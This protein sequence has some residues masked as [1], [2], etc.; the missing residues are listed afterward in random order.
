MPTRSGVEFLTPAPM[1]GS[2]TG[3]PSFPEVVVKLD[4]LMVRMEQMEQRFAESEQ[5]LEE[6]VTEST[7]VVQGMVGRVLALERPPPTQDQAPGNQPARR[8]PVEPPHRVEQHVG[9]GVDEDVSDYDSTEEVGNDFRPAAARERVDLGYDHRFFR[10]PRDRDDRNNVGFE[11][12]RHQYPRGCGDRDEHGLEYRRYRPPRDRDD[13]DDEDDRRIVHVDAPTFDGSLDPRAYLDWEANMNRYFDWMGMSDA[14][15]TRFAMIKLVGQA[16]TYWLNVDALLEQRGLMPIESWED[17]KVKLREKYLPTTYRHRLIDRWQDLTQGTRIVFEYIADFDEYLLR[18]GACEEGAMTLSRFRKGLRRVYQHELFRQHVTTIEHNY[19]VVSEMEQFE[20][21]RESPPRARPAYPRPTKQR[22]A[23]RLPPRGPTLGPTEPPP[24]PRFL[25]PREAAPVLPTP[26]TRPQLPAPPVRRD[27]KGKAPM[28]GGVSQDSGS[29]NRCFRCQG[30][31]HYM[32]ACPTRALTIEGIDP[33]GSSYD[34][35]EVGYAA[36]EDL[37]LEYQ[38]ED[39][40]AGP[41][42][43]PSFEEVPSQERLGVVRC[44]LAQ[45]KENT[46]WRRTSI[47]QTYCR[48]SSRVCRVIVDN[49]SCELPSRCLGCRGLSSAYYY[50][51][52]QRG[53]TRPRLDLEG[54]YRW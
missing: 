6:R 27:E 9:Q 47:F 39:E 50:R 42:H 34:L 3:S 22:S 23:P 43:V 7:R 51:Y 45:P 17:M 14:R 38:L 33:G 36:G 29:R 52:P 31:G 21:G 1:A 26:T 44:I 13:R 35:Q 2:Q 53:A 41:A 18:C 48:L 16:Q 25:P 11:Q 49:G 8:D 12:P 40:L 10:H 32:S 4:Q 28:G 30:F 15:R 19:Q 37:A 54:P 5:R 46:D 24:Q 20:L